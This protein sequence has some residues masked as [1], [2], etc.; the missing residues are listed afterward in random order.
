MSERAPVTLAEPFRS[1]VDV[2]VLLRSQI[3]YEADRKVSAE[4]VPML[5]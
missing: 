2:Q 5:D 3:N 1:L 4:R